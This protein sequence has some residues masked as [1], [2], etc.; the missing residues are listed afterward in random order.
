MLLNPESQYG[1]QEFDNPDFAQQYG[2]LEVIK[3]T[4]VSYLQ[5]PRV[6]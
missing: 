4:L 2:K 3:Q 5:G 6:Q 1:M